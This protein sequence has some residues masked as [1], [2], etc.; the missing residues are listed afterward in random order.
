MDLLGRNFKDI[1]LRLFRHVLTTSYFSFNGQ[2][3]EQ[4]DGVALG[5]S[6]SL[7][8]AKL[9]MKDFEERALDLAPHKPR[10]WFRY[11]DDT[12]VILPHRDDK[13]KDFLNHINNIHQCIKF[14]M[15]TEI[16]GHLPFLDIDIYTET[17]RFSGP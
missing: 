17:R 9:Y 1:I 12:S 8:I 11:V 14:T 5:S 16:E 15:E 6:L 13:L 4:T 10:C 7:V 2:F 3:Y